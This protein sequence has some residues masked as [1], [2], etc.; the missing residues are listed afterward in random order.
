MRFG[1]R[2]PVFL[3]ILTKESGYFADCI[4]VKA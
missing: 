2:Q 1:E 4:E 3:I